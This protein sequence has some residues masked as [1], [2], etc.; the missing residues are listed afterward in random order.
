[1]QNYETLRREAWEHFK[2]AKDDHDGIRLALYDVTAK[3]QRLYLKHFEHRGRDEFGDPAKVR[4][5]ATEDKGAN[6]S[7]S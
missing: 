4:G 2:K 6:E 7:S 5:R 3:H 1:M